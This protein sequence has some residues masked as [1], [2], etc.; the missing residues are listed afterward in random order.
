MNLLT[1]PRLALDTYLK[2]VKWPLDRAARIAG[3]NGN[4]AANGAEIALDRADATVRGAAGVVLNDAELQQDA[5]LR[6]AAASERARALELRSKAEQISETSDE[7][8]EQRKRQAEKRKQQAS[9]TAAQRKQQAEKARKERERKAAQT[10]S[11]RKAANAKATAKVEESIEERAKRERLEAIE[12]EAEALE[13]KGEALTASD[14]AQ[15]LAKAA[16]T[17]KAQRKSD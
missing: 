3:G 11:K 14:E 17:A 8:L 15:R 6:H 1:I 4:G 13:E 5:Q 10:T 7:E 2:A 16:A 9:K 12:R